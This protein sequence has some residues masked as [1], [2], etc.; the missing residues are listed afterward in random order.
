MRFFFGEIV[1]AWQ[2]LASDVIGNAAPILDRLEKTV[3]DALLTP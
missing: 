1:S 2:R 3:D